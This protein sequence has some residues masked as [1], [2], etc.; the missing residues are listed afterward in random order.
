MIP[1][2]FTE[3]IILFLTLLPFLSNQLFMCLSLVQALY[4]VYWSIQLILKPEASFFCCWPYHTA[5]GILVPQP[6]IE[7]LPPVLEV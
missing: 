2:T 3:E 5:C 6:E 7:P 4:F 1:P